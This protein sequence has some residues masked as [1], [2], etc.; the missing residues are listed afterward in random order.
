MLILASKSP[1]R[2]D[3]LEQKGL[4]FLTVP[5]EFD[6]SSIS[7]DTPQTY[8]KKLAYLKAKSVLDRYPNDLIIGADTI[9]VYNQEILGK[10]KD[11]LDA[12]TMLK[13]LVGQKHHV[14][15]AVSL[16]NREKD[17]TWLSYA[18]VTF[19]SVTDE[20]LWAYVKTKEPM[21]KAGAYGIQGIGSFL[22]LSYY[23]NYHA[24]M[25]LPIDEVIERLSSF[26]QKSIY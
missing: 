3:L 5:S 8:V 7:E 21:D 19:K 4:K 14:Y 20:D 26:E 15:T 1:R 16:V 13:K 18:E 12:F 6:E 10:P 25:G 23:G 11:E 22:V 9:V 2:R 24:I 17:V